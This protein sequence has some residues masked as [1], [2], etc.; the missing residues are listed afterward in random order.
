MCEKHNQEC[1]CYTCRYMDRARG[2]YLYAQPCISCVDL[3]TDDCYWESTDI[4]NQEQEYDDI[5][6]QADADNQQ[7]EEEEAAQYEEQTRAED[8]ANAQAE[9]DAAAAEAEAQYEEY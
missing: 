3:N 2:C 6:A 1:E 9:A 8:E 4:Y 7:Q 5:Q